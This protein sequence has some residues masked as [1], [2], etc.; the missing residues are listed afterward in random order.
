MESLD[1]IRD[2]CAGSKTEETA[3]APK[4]EEK[5]S[6]PFSFF[7]GAQLPPS[8]ASVHTSCGSNLR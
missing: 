2:D 6:T 3:P 5:P 8:L 4:A 7:G 1:S